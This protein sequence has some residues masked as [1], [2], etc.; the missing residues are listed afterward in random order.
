M[1]DTAIDR[2]STLALRDMTDEDFVALYGSDRF[3]A[4]VLQSRLGYIVQHVSTGVLHRSFSP[5]IAFGADFA[6]AII[7]PPE[8]DYPMSAVNNGLA[9]FLGTMSDG[10]RNAVEEF[11]P[12]RLGPGDMLLC[13]DTSRMGNHPNDVCF[14]RPMFHGGRIIGFMTIRAHQLDIGGIAPGGF[15]ATKRSIYENGLIISP[16][17]IYQA[18]VPVRETFSLIFDNARYAELLLPDLKTLYQCCALGEQLVDETVERYGVD[19]YLG[20][21]RYCCD[22]TA[23]NMATAIQT[24]PDG[25]YEGS[26]LIDA[27]GVDASEE[28]T[29]HLRL[30][31]R[32]SRIEA[33]FSETSRQSRTCINAGPLDVK[34]AI[35]VGLKILLDPTSE[36]NSGSFRSI[37]ILVPPGS[38]VGALPPD[39]PIFHYWEV[40]SAMVAALLRAL[41]GA[42][43]DRAIGGDYGSSNLHNAHGRWPDGGLWTSASMVGGESGA[44]GA[45]SAGD[46][47]GMNGHYLLNF[48]APGTEM[49]EATS[50]TVVLRREYAIDTGGPGKHRGGPGIMRDTLW[51]AAADH[52][53][54][55][56]RMKRPSGAGVQGAGH[57]PN[58]GV[59]LFGA[60]TQGTGARADTFLPT[61]GEAVYADSTPVAGVMNPETHALDPEGGE[62]VYFASLPV[63]HTEAGAM[64]RYVTNGGGGWGPPHEREIEAVKRDV[65]D[66][67]VSIAAA[68]RDYGVVITGDPD[69]DPEG[70]AVDEAATRE[71]RAALAAAA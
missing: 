20:A 62:Y 40:Q 21:V 60:E 41:E 26:E 70:L 4:S 64:W 14:M 28:Y 17:L 66:G 47:E 45:T 7:G 31:K 33:D 24:L 9:I 1:L 44:W 39:G 5:I 35:G 8:Q 34:T 48:R 29:V 25:D 36:F 3:T 12:E 43:G 10:V 19:A 69:N 67:Y 23:E 30:K 6:T 55:P 38:I 63:W 49:A 71:R 58:G 42:L 18:G 32:G 65:R 37:D 27:D 61:S 46:A 51:T 57:G 11:G 15:S 56:L 68:E 13:N 52:Y 2:T 22:L 59:W 16:R 53:S 54:T 50:P